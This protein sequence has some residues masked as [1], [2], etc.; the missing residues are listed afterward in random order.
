MEIRIISL[1]LRNFK[2]VRNAEYHFGGHNARIEGPNGSGKSTVFDSF[3][4]LLFGKDHRDQ[5]AD[6]FEIKTIDPATGRPYPREDHWVEAELTVDGQAHTLRRCWVENW[7]K[8]TGEIDDVMK[9]HTSAFFV[10]GVDVGTKRAYDAAVGGWMQ[11]AVFKLLTNPLYF[12]DD[13]FTPWRNRRKAL[14]DLVKDAPERSRVREE[15]ADV[16]GKLSGR[17][18]EEYRK[19]I[20]MEK[21]ANK[22]DL[23]AILSRIDGMRE[24][25]PEAADLTSYE[26][27]LHELAE[28]RDRALSEIKSK[29]AEIDRAIASEDEADAARKAEN[30]AIWAE[31]TKLQLK[32]GNYLAEAK[33]GAQTQ[34]NDREN[35][36]LAARHEASS[37]MYEKSALDEKEKALRDRIDE[38]ERDRGRLASLLADLGEEYKA[39]KA[40]AFHFEPQDTCPY[41][42]QAI[43]AASIA[44]AREKEYAAFVEM[45]KGKVA[46]VI[47]EAKRIKA[48]VAGMD[49]ALK[50][51]KD[52][53]AEVAAKREQAV[54][55]YD[56]C[57]AEAKRLEA[58]PQVDVAAIEARVQS[59]DEYRAMMRE[60]LDLRAKAL[61]TSTRPEGLEELVLKRKELERQAAYEVERYTKAELDAKEALSVGK[62]REDQL[63][64][65]AQKEN[66]AK[67]FADALASCE[68]Q[69]ARAA[70]F[71]KAEI[72]SVETAIGN[73]FHTA[74]WKMF[75]RTIDGGIVETCEVCDPDGTPYRSMNDAMKILCGIDCIRVFSHTYGSVAPIFI[76]NAEGILKES[77]DTTAQVIRLVVK[78]TEKITLITE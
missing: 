10:D 34:N 21:A 52:D 71:V 16:V 39:H 57:T 49:A 28:R 11:E 40:L 63:K 68:R 33:K 38:G 45:Q 31:I 15:F 61:K 42:G 59:S 20:A 3:T 30:A 56:R 53:L 36:I 6:T 27:K 17:S 22:R 41:C 35:A 58:Q 60:E 73:L 48:Q 12:I 19:R 43:P 23:T 14:M 4:W 1:R 7:V 77:F 65:I 50:A 26:R 13:A 47:D 72:D 9:G 66:E 8:P 51:L 55:E 70:E 44:E 32:M 18:I 76:D 67:N 25:L 74:R 78:D 37:R 64:L 29:V 75:D 62:V 54:A 5:T 24:A 2:G 69:E 46:K